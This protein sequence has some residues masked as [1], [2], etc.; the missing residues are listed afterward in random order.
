MAYLFL[1]RMPGRQIFVSLLVLPTIIS[2]IVAGA[3]WR[4]LLDTY[5]GDR[6]AVA[7]A[8]VPPERAGR[9]VAADTLHQTFNFDFLAVPF[10]ADAIVDLVQR[11]LAT[12]APVGA[13]A[14]WALSNHDSPRLVT[15]LV[16]GLALSKPTF[17]Y[18]GESSTP[19][20]ARSYIAR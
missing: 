20:H 9:Y 10:E 2:P 14:T 4:L 6:M 11:T 5:P 3:T 13:P 12:L 19:G 8:N 18:A 17:R 16:H 15:R 7:E 1:E